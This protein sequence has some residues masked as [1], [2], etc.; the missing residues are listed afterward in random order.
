LMCGLRDQATV[1]AVEGESYEVVQS[2]GE[3]NQVV[4]SI[5]GE[6]YELQPRAGLEPMEPIQ[7]SDAFAS[8]QLGLPAE[9]IEPLFTSETGVPEPV[10]YLVKNEDLIATNYTQQD[11]GIAQATRQVL[12]NH[13]TPGSFAPPPLPS[14]GGMPDVGDVTAELEVSSSLFE[15]NLFSLFLTIGGGVSQIRGVPFGIRASNLVGS[16]I[17]GSASSCAAC[18]SPK[19]NMICAGCKKTLYCDTGCQKK[20][21]I[22]GG[23]SRD[24]FQ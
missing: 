3:S 24:C 18:H 8:G 9:S 21:W 13:T 11:V 19:A 2:T 23:H 16:K 1:F 20:H 5:T 4:N 14:S 17:S 12:K 22:A 15:R 7:T 10:Q 6:V